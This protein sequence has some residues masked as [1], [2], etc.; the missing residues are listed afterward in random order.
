MAKKTFSVVILIW[1][2]I[3]LIVNAVA[4][5]PDVYILAKG[6]FVDYF[7]SILA[8]PIE[9]GSVKNVI[10]NLVYFS[11]TSFVTFVVSIIFVIGWRKDSWTRILIVAGI[12]LFI[13]N[14]YALFY[15]GYLGGIQ[16]IHNNLLKYIRKQIWA[17]MPLLCAIAKAKMNKTKTE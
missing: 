7:N 12:V 6:L 14:H 3:N 13:F 9:G 15:M 1:G 10:L 17:L 4:L 16:T 11:G 5:V 2:I 8:Q